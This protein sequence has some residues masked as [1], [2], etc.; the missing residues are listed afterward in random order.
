[1]ARRKRDREAGDLESAI[2]RLMD[3]LVARC[4]RGELEA[5][6]ALDRLETDARS[7]LMLGVLGYRNGPA[8]ASWATIGEIVGTTRQGAQQRFSTVSMIEGAILR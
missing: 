1:M 4:E 8:E 5:L 7:A 3:A 6:E 2:G